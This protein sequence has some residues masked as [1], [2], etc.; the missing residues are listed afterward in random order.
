[1]NPSDQRCKYCGEQATQFVF[2]QFVCDKD[3]CID[4]A[5]DERG[6]PGGGKPL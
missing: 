5:R 1:M 6:G 4:R 3:E 2:A